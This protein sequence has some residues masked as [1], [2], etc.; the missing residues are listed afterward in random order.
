MT[1]QTKPSLPWSESIW[2]FDVDDTLINTAELTE[3]SSLSMVPI[4]EKSVGKEKAQQLREHFLQIFATMLAG[5]RL[6]DP[7]EWEKQPKLKKE[8]NAFVEKMES[9]QT[10]IQ[11]E[12]GGI[13][14]WSREIFIQLAADKVGV[15]LTPSVIDAAADAY[16]TTLAEKAV[17]LEGVLELF[18]EILT[19]DRPVFLVTGSDAHLQRK[20][21]DQFTYVPTYSEEFKLKR[22]HPLKEKGLHFH[23]VSIGDPV[24]KPH[25]DFFEKALK[26]AAEKLDKTIDPKNVIMIGDSFQ[27]DLQVPKEELGFGLVVLFEK[28]RVEMQIIDERYVVTG[29]LSEIS[30]FFY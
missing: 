2:F 18:Q 30:Q 26:M 6:H 13:K 8:Y 19:H 23:G 17:V 12:F 22:I 14:R 24:D 4:L 5:H 10:H 25:R 28:G 15:Q 7:A 11:Q 20:D 9:Y 1:F 16:W 27:S 3:V 29:N 21:D